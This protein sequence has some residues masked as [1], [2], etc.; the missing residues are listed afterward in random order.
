M[1]AKNKRVLTVIR[2]SSE[3]MVENMHKSKYIA[4]I[5][6]A[7]MALTLAGCGG[8]GGELIGNTDSDGDT[9]TYRCS[10]N[11]NTTS[12]FHTGTED[13]RYQDSAG[14]VYLSVKQ[15]SE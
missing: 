11:R 9:D 13:D 1:N 12:D 14:E 10:G 6:A 7:A 8:K 4:M 5:A 2:C 15:S 3:R